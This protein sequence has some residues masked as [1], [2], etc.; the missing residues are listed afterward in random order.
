MSRSYRKPF[1]SACG[2]VSSKEDKICAS[3]AVRRMSREWIRKFKREGDWDSF[4][5]PLRLECPNN[6]RW[7]WA[8]DGGKYP[9]GKKFRNM[10]LSEIGIAI[11]DN[12]YEAFQKA[13][14]YIN[15]YCYE[16]EEYLKRK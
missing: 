11:A 2:K 13:V 10:C 15:K 5:V 16:W 1:S 6:E 7:G 14:S 9:V 12:D 8:C 3:R 4:R